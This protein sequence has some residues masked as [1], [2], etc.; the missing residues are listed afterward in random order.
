MVHCR[1]P[2]IS[3]YAIMRDIM[4][5]LLDKCKCIGHIFWGVLGNTGLC[6]AIFTRD[7]IGYSAYMLSPVRLSLCLS[8][9]WIIEKRVKIGL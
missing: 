5:H 4:R 7:S 2:C 6:D 8:D 3:H 9:G 1:Q